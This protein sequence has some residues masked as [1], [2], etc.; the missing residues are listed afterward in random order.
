MGEDSTA[1]SSSSSSSSGSDSDSDSDSDSSGSSSSS[2]TTSTVECEY[3]HL[4]KDWCPG[5]KKLRTIAREVAD[6]NDCPKYSKKISKEIMEQM[7]GMLFYRTIK[8]DTDDDDSS[9]SDSSDDDGDS[10]DSKSDSSD[11]ES[12]VGEYG[13]GCFTEDDEIDVDDEDDVEEIPPK[14]LYEALPPFYVGERF[15]IQE[16]AHC[17]DVYFKHP[18]HPGTEAFGTFIVVVVLSFLL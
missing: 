2:S 8:N 17:R 7:D 5:T 11:D 9:D 6:E 13:F 1:S 10:S 18:N 14:E 15:M 12:S 4:N 16:E 3:V